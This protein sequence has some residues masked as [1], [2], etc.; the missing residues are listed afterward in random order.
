MN[1]LKLVA[2]NSARVTL[3]PL[4]TGGILMTVINEG[5]LTQHQIT[6]ENFRQSK[7]DFFPSLLESLIN[8]NKKRAAEEP[9]DD[10]DETRL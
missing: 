2:D 4:I 9:E 3:A 10:E 8:T 6:E 5:K 7:Q 1:T